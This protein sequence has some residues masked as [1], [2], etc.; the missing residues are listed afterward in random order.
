MASVKTLLAGESSKSPKEQD[1]EF[2]LNCRVLRETY[3]DTLFFHIFDLYKSL[4]LNLL[5]GFLIKKLMPSPPRLTELFYMNLIY[6][7]IALVSKVS[8][9][10]I[11]LTIQEFGRLYKLPYLWKS[12]T[13]AT[14]YGSNKFKKNIAIRSLLIDPM[15]S[16]KLVI[17][18]NLYFFFY[19]LL[20]NL[21]LLVL[22][23]VN[24]VTHIRI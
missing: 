16:C 2:F 19:S 13:I 20:P 3:L 23:K 10:K 22:S 1:E 6:K 17:N 8:I 24:M 9:T 4:C 21:F 7:N 15:I 18:I 12:Y 5:R 14:P 11:Y